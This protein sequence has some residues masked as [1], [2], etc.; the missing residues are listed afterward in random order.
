[1]YLSCQ[2]KLINNLYNIGKSIHNRFYFSIYPPLIT[3]TIS[4]RLGK[5]GQAIKQVLFCFKHILFQLGSRAEPYI[6]PSC[7]IDAGTGQN[8]T[9][10]TQRG[11][12]NKNRSEFCGGTLSVHNM[13][14]EHVTWTRQIEGCGYN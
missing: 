4:R 1:M 7:R 13:E 12:H 2:Y 3:M 14:I 6:N 10:Q 9:K 8:M 5:A 11:F